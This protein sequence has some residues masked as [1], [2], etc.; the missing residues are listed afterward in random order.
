MTQSSHSINLN[1]DQE[2]KQTADFKEAFVSSLKEEMMAVPNNNRT[3][4]QMAT[5]NMLVAKV[6]GICSLSGHT[7]DACL[8][9]QEDEIV[10]QVNVVGTF[11]GQHPHQCDS[12]V[13]THNPG[14]RGYPDLSYEVPANSGTSMDDMFKALMSQ[15]QQFMN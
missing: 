7:C 5:G 13:N 6:C 14:W 11:L 9:L 1:F 12:W 15:T 10:H 2:I 4:R 3:L 8:V